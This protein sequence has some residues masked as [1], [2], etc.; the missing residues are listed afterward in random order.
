MACDQSI[1]KDISVGFE[2][3]SITRSNQT[4]SQTKNFSENT[5]PLHS[6]VTY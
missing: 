3:L 2:R 5:P 6:I 1:E 4:S